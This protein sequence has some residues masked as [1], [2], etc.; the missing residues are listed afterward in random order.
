MAD[1]LDSRLESHPAARYGGHHNQ[2]GEN[3]ALY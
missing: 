2:G 3:D 1:L